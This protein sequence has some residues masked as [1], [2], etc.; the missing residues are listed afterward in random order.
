MRARWS[1]G[2]SHMPSWCDLMDFRYAILDVDDVLLTTQQAEP[3]AARALLEALSAYL[4]SEKA[5]AVHREF[6]A[7]WRTLQRRHWSCAETAEDDYAVLEQSIAHWQRGVTEQGY[8]IKLWSRQVLLACALAS[9]RVDVSERLVRGVTEAYWQEMA[10]S[11]KVHPDGVAAIQ[12]LG[13]TGCQVHLATDS[14]GFLVFDESEQTF[15]YDPEASAR[16][17][18]HRLRALWSL[19][20]GPRD[21]TIGDPIGKPDPE[22]SKRTIAE[23][24]GKVGHAVDVRRTVVVGDSFARDVEPFLRVG[25]AFGVWLVRD[26]AD[27]ETRS[28]GHARVAVVSSLAESWH[29]APTG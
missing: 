15:T 3:R 19:G 2:H 26:R 25:V 29:T 12:R 10:E 7:H 1:A 16:E 13:S 22:F 24:S 23:F 17:K 5:A 28:C 21:V 27:D 9:Q 4:D 8:Q 11:V 18:I 20:L 6:V 14:D